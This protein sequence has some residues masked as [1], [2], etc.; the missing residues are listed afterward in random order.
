MDFSRT[1]LDG[2]IL[3]TPEKIRDGR[4][5]FAET[6]RH[7]LFQE[8]C[9]E[10]D[11]V[12]ES[13]SC[14]VQTGTVR[15]LHFQ[16]APKAQG[17]LVRCVS[18]AFLDVAVDM[19]P[20]SPGF[21]GHATMELSAENGRQLW[22]PAGFAHGFCTLMPDTRISYKATEYYSKEHERGISWNDPDLGISWPVRTENAVLSD[23][24]KKS[25]SLIDWRERLISVGG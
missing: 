13:Q 11:F 12:Q 19:R 10:H 1:A 20:G 4:G 25:P 15:G 17:K 6:F 2:V 18:G 24:D 3:I 7:D 16:I 14:S 21:G 23:R 9:G 22:I 8:N 5:Y